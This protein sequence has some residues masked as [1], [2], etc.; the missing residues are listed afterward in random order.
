MP[1]IKE[2]KKTLLSCLIL[3]GVLIACNPKGEKAETEEKKE[4]AEATGAVNYAVD[5]V[6]LI[7]WACSKPT[8]THT[9]TFMIKQGN[10]NIENGNIKA[11]NFVIDINSIT[12]EDLLSDPK[13]HGMLVGHLKSPDFFDV[14]KYPE[15]KFEITSVEPA[16]SAAM[17]KMKE[18]T[19]VI[20]GNLTLKDSTKNIAFPARVTI[21]EQTI[22]AMADFNIDRTQWGMNYKGP[23]NPAD[24]VISKEVNMKLMITGRKM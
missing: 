5:S 14:A 19:H 13:S 1:K 6:S 15:G 11:G 9:G 21:D 20:K 22:S 10:F 12:D 8:G 3:S 2:M 7:K 4:V 17:A 24:F 23:N 18:A 16:D